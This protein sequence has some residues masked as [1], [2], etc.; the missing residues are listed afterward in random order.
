MMRGVRCKAE[1]IDIASCRWADR[2]AAGR[3]A[4]SVLVT[5]GVQTPPHLGEGPYSAPEATFSWR[6][7]PVL[8][9]WTVRAAAEVIVSSRG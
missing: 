3:E 1:V 6:R 4:I 8:R 5:G 7:P 9:F 2:A